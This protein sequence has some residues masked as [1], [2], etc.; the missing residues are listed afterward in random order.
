MLEKED[1]AMLLRMVS[2]IVSSHSMGDVMIACGA[3]HE[4]NPFCL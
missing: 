4:D 1:V 2:G 3:E